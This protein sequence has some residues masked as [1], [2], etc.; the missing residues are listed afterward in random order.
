MNRQIVEA[1]SVKG[2]RQTA[3]ER[4]QRGPAS[5][6]RRER[7]PRWFYLDSFSAKVHWGMLDIVSAKREGKH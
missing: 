1:S 7:E 2:A 4:P 3:P 5:G 6:N